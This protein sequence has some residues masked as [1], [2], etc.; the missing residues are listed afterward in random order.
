MS[1]NHTDDADKQSDSNAETTPQFPSLM[2]PPDI[3]LPQK[4]SILH[5]M[6]EKGVRLPSGLT[7]TIESIPEENEKQRFTV[8]NQIGQGGMSHVYRV[9]D[10]D[11]GRTIAVKS[12]RLDKSNPVNF[13]RALNEMQITGQLEHPNILP[14]HDVGIDDNNNIYFSMKLVKGENLGSIL[15]NLR[16]TKHY[17]GFNQQRL[18]EIFM[19]ICDAVSL[20]HSKDVIHRDL[21]PHNIMVGEFGEVLLMDWGLAKIVKP[22]KLSRKF[23]NTK[24]IHRKD[25]TH[26][27]TKNSET[28]YKSRNKTKY[29]Y[30]TRFGTVA[31]TPAFMPPEQALGDIENIDARSDIYSLGAI[32]YHIL[33]Y[34]P[35]FIGTLPEI[36][37]KVAKGDLRNPTAVNEN[38]P[39]ELETIVLKAMAHHKANRF[40]TVKQLKDEIQA[41]LENKP[42][43]AISY[44]VFDLSRKFW[45]RNKIVFAWSL[46]SAIIAGFVVFIVL[47]QHFEKTRLAPD[48]IDN[49]NVPPQLLEIDTSQI[50]SEIA[51]IVSKIKNFDAEIKKTDRMLAN[52]DDFNAFGLPA[53]G[54]YWELLDKKDYYLRSQYKSFVDLQTYSKHFDNYSNNSERIEFA[55]ARLLLNELRQKFDG[56][57]TQLKMIDSE[58]K[59]SEYLLRIAQKKPTK[60]QITFNITT[61]DNVKIHEANVKLFRFE[62][63]SKY[64]NY[65]RIIPVPYKHKTDIKHLKLRQDMTYSTIH[66]IVD[67]WNKSG[68]VFNEIK[69]NRE[70][71]MQQGDYLL[72]VKVHFLREPVFFGFSVT[73]LDKYQINLVILDENFSNDFAFV[74]CMKIGE[75]N[76]TQTISPF[77]IAKSH[78]L[79]CEYLKFLNDR[80][81]PKNLF[82]TLDKLLPRLDDNT[83][84]VKYDEKTKTVVSIIADAESNPVT[85]INYEDI[86][87]YLSWL[88]E[89]NAGKGN[90]SLMSAQNYKRMNPYN[91]HYIWGYRDNKYFRL[92]QKPIHFFADT[93]IFGIEGLNTGIQEFIVDSKTPQKSPID[94]P[95]LFATSASSVAKFKDLSPIAHNYHSENI[96]FRLVY[97]SN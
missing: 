8:L 69:L 58:K 44:T 7:K 25:E 65:T 61:A 68:I 56:S 35:P 40:Q 52:F 94:K 70:L 63:G 22:R 84:T 64:H 74:P 39:K 78:V 30:E 11:I 3:K 81:N 46:V 36:I 59:M 93:N 72:S 6:E 85:G 83:P 37:E 32:L 88:N 13:K 26:E 97:T 4:E 75:S 19:K 43:G 45:K 49:L 66:E 21:K 91:W 5:E 86:T 34:F 29:A 12:I 41:F 10:R 1:D 71:T 2:H 96:G 28:P 17:K 23:Q 15:E 14:L 92:A 73:Q 27:I 18:L 48:I 57:I 50:K 60:A 67:F 24:S 51:D 20:A 87:Q 76:K 47:K 16:K 42:I 90:Y 79:L 80:K 54:F 33:T 89:K 55:K 82:L 53:T 38:I 31:G 77:Y 9:L 95:K 62:S